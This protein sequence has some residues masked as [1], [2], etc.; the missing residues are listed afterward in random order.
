MPQETVKGI[1]LRERASRICLEGIERG[2]RHRFYGTKISL[3]N[4]LINGSNSIVRNDE[5]I[6]ESLQQRVEALLLALFAYY[7]RAHS[8]FFYIVIILVRVNFGTFSFLSSYLLSLHFAI[9]VM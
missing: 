5:M 8:K 9:S 6:D 2:V 7:R 3:Q 1:N 4:A